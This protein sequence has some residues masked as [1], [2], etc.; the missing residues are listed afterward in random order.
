LFA[1]F[2]VAIVITM[3]T[4]A[5]SMRVLSGRDA[6]VVHERA[7]VER[8]VSA[9][10]GRVWNNPVD[11]DWYA[12][13][14][15]RDLGVGVMVIDRNGTPLIS[16]MDQSQTAQNASTLWPILIRDER[17]Q[18]LGTVK[19][20]LA[21]FGFHVGPWRTL[22]MLAAV[23][24]VLWAISNKV[25]RRISRPLEELTQVARA[26]GEG[27]LSRRACLC[28][29]HPGE[30]GELTRAV[31]EMASRIERQLRD[32]RQLLA[33]VSHEL[34]TPMARIRILLEMARDG[35]SV[36]DGRNPLDEIEAEIVEM[37]SLV[38]ELLASARMEFS[39]LSRRDLSPREVAERAVERASLPG[40]SVDVEHGVSQVTADATLVARALGAVLDNA[41]KYGRGTIQLRVHSTEKNTVAFSVEDQGDGFTPGDEERV[42]EPFFRSRREGETEAR[43]VGLGLALVRRIAEAHGGRAYAVNRPEGGARVTIELPVAAQ[44]P[45]AGDTTTALAAE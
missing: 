35:V 10:F 6:S 3:L 9:N 16:V 25:A 43:G 28:Y 2:G 17:G 39:A 24:L 21:R 19:L 15:H 32:Q 23:G 14:L 18:V 8:F 38:G 7:R 34:R 12:R 42:F 27:D 29:S 1:W 36:G 41:R 11:R 40:S 5:L 45:V 44:N 4:V 26:L 20:N 30:V 37:D 33:A 31:N 13:E 22:V